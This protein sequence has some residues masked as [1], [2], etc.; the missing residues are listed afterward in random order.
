MESLEEKG[1]GGGGTGL[2]NLDNYMATYKC[3]NIRNSNIRGVLQQ[4]YFH[5]PLLPSPHFRGEVI[6]IVPAAPF[7][8]RPYGK[9]FK[10]ALSY[11]QLI[12][13]MTGF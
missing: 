1:R 7:F 2:L 4:K 12:Y 8:S 3:D 11:Q 10:T 5:P 9:P 6:R 13:Y